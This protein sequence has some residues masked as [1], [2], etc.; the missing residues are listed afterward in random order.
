ME[1]APPR[2]PAPPTRSTRALPRVAII[3]GGP[4]GLF[5][6]YELQRLVDRPLEVT[7]YEASDRLGGKVR[8]M[9]FTSADVRYEEGA[10]EIYE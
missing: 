3:G 5:T 1:T 7:L 4:G 6:A 8:T 10:A 2:A 9:R